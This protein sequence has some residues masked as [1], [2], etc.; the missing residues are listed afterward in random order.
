DKNNK[1]LYSNVGTDPKMLGIMASEGL[2]IQQLT[3]PLQDIHKINLAIFGQGINYDQK[4]AGIASG[5]FE[6]G[7]STLTKSNEI[8]I[9]IWVKNNAKWWSEGTIVD[10]A[11]VSG[12]QYL[13]NQEIMKIPTT[14]SGGGL[15]TNVIPIWVKNNAKWWSEGTISDQDFVLGIQ[16]LVTNGI[17]KIK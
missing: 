9:P 16:Y 2:D 10:S 17:I 13:I 14:T 15:T 8:A 12:I 3:I 4:Y 6:V 11:F 7:P 5:I 1:E